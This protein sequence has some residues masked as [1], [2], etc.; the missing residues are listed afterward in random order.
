MKHLLATYFCLFAIC[1]SC[2]QNSGNQTD[3][4]TDTASITYA[5][6]DTDFPNPDRGFYRYSETRASNYTPLSVEGLSELRS[7]EAADGAQYGTMSTL[8]FRYFIL[9]DFVDKPISQDFLNQIQL[10][11]DAIRDAGFKMIPRF[12]YTVTSNAGNC[13][14]GFIC[15]PYGDAPKVVVLG[16]IQ[17]LSP[18]LENNSDVITAV[19]MGFI[20]TWGENYYTDFFGDA[21]SNA[22]QGKLLDVNWLDRIEVLKALLDATPKDL[23]VQVRYPQ[24]KQRF[25]EGIKAPTTVAALSETEAFSDTDKARLGFHND[26]LFASPDDFGTYMDYGN[27]SSERKEDIAHLKPY[28]EEEGKYVIVGGETCTDVYSPE[29]DCSPAGMAD[30]DLR[31]LHYTYLNADF[32]HDVNND[33]VTGGC[34][35]EIKKNLGYRFQLQKSILPKNIIS[36]K[37]FNI[38][39][40]LENVGYTS[41]VKKR[42]VNLLLRNTSNGQVIT[43]T[44]ETDVRRWHSNVTLN[45][46]F[47]SPNLLLPG[48]YEL[49]LQLEENYQT[50]KNRPEYSIRFANTGVWESDTGYNTLNHQ[51]S[52]IDRQTTE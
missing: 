19:Q 39:I 41:P 43:F 2:S 32:N 14:E 26:C 28:F 13:P 37:S 51:V 8:I 35:E 46:T 16:H 31:K 5:N 12:T 27:S 38:T 7:S 44:F 3:P 47:A 25:I 17:Q 36:G 11:F 48:T 23:M 21:S 15:P 18:L 1:S 45:Q 50:L 42:N 22:Y 4:D 10:D 49:L 20:G 34:M 9:D 40:M 24:M 6:D 30:S 52:V 33:W 29:N